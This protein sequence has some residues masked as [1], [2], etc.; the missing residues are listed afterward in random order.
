MSKAFHKGPFL[1]RAMSEIEAEMDDTSFKSYVRA[2]ETARLIEHLGLGD[3]PWR[4]E[5]TPWGW[6]FTVEHMHRHTEIEVQ[7]DFIEL[8]TENLLTG[9]GK[10]LQKPKRRKDGDYTYERTLLMLKPG[11]IMPSESPRERARRE[12]VALRQK[13]QVV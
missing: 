7:R 8:Y 4:I 9:T 5:R 1:K 2:I 11:A 13:A 10:S 6:T 3:L 12:R